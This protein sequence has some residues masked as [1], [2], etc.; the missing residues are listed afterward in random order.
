MSELSEARRAE[1]SGGF[2]WQITDRDLD[3]NRILIARGGA[4]AL[5]HDGTERE[6]RAAALIDRLCDYLSDVLIARGELPP[7][8]CDFPLTA[9]ESIAYRQGKPWRTTSPGAPE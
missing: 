7:T 1:Y 6:R 8:G 2:L 3:W 5:A 4:F 9:E